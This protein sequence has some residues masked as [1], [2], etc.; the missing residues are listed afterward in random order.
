[1]KKRPEIF[2]PP[3]FFYYTFTAEPAKSETTFS[4]RLQQVTLDAFL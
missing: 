1:M 2:K 4:P 3:L